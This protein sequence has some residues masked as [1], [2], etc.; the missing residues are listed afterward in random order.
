MSSRRVRAA[1]RATCAALAL[2]GCNSAAERGVRSRPPMK[3]P[4][5][6]RRSVGPSR[7]AGSTPPTRWASPAPTMPSSSWPGSTSSWT[8]PASIPRSSPPRPPRATCPTCCRWTAVWS[9]P[10]PTKDLIVALDECYAVHGV[11]E[12]A[13]LLV[14]HRRCHLRR[15]GV[16]RAA[17]LPAHRVHRRRADQDPRASR[18]PWPAAL[19]SRWPR[20]PRTSPRLVPG[21]STPR[22]RP[23][24]SPLARRGPRRC[25]RTR[26]STPV[27]SPRLRWPT[28][29]SGP[30][31]QASGNADFDQVIPTFYEVLPGNVSR[32]ASAVGQ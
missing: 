20:R 31:R 27:C 7:S 30:S 17:V 19:P 22:R 12:P 11:T 18:W 8:P 29:P 4:P 9:P 5:S 24:G 28:R 2:A 21:R 25:R 32:G 1:A 23:P 16:R 10:R 14:D 3:A 15:Q 26:A 13:V 6:P